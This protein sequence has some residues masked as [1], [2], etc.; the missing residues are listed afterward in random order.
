MATRRDGSPL[1][2][3]ICGGSTLI[4]TILRC[5]PLRIAACQHDGS[6]LIE[7]IRRCNILLIA[8]LLRYGSPRIMAR[9]RGGSPLIPHR[10]RLPLGLSL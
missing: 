8:A 3:A 5:G 6:P 9:L 4:A 1:I 10:R 2:A 7:A